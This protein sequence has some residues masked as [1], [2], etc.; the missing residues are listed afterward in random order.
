MKVMLT[1]GAGFLGER[2]TRRLFKRGHCSPIHERSVTRL[3]PSMNRVGSKLVMAILLAACCH[4][5]ILSQAQI[6]GGSQHIQVGEADV[7]RLQRRATS[8]GRKLEF[9]SVT[10]FPGRGMNAFQI[11]ANIPGK[12]ETPLL[13]SPSLEEA[14][15][16]L[17]GEGKDR[18][19]VLNHSFG[20]A[21]LIPFS[22]RITGELSPDGQLLTTKWRGKTITLPL[23]SGTY[24][25][26]GLLNTEK[27]QDLKTSRTAD[28]ETQ[29]GIIH[30]GDFD[31]HWLSKSDLHF[32]ICAERRS[33]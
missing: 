13:K 19:G 12:G 20:G 15:Q 9:L 14:A 24:A 4:P 17:S 7:V 25:T 32:T 21:F 30:A 3:G 5:L 31:G 18:W 2:L 27:A 10:L 33:C 8:H 29:T 28:G 23:N 26:H 22:S 6:A 16:Q 11:T 1:G